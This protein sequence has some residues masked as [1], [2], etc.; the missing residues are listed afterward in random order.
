MSE[1]P[2]QSVPVNYVRVA[3]NGSEELLSECSKSSGILAESHATD[4]YIVCRP[5][6]HDFSSEWVG[7]CGW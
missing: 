6:D 2:P 1:R 5:R 4:V 7:G 3:C